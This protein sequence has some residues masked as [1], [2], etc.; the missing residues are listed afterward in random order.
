MEVF[1]LGVKLELQH[2]PTPQ[3]QQCRIRAKS[4]TY[5]TVHANARPLLNPLGE[6]RG[7]IPL[8]MDPS[9]VR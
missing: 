8:L 2:Q 6:A 5:A 4:A 7:Q 9:W 1:R 3:P